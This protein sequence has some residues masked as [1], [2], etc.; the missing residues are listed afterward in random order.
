MTSP[1]ALGGERLPA[2]GSIVTRVTDVQFAKFPEAK[3][4][5]K[6]AAG[7]VTTVMGSDVALGALALPSASSA[8]TR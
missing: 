1:R 2:P 5:L 3:S 6:M 4:S 7:A 8:I